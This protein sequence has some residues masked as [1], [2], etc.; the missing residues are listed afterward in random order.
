MNKKAT[1]LDI[2]M[3]L[4]RIANWAV[5]DY[6]RKKKRINFFLEETSQQIKSLESFNFDSLFK[7]TWRHFLKEYLRL[8]K[9]GEKEP[10]DKLYWA[11]MMMTWG[12]IL[13]HRAQLIK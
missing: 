9:E 6:G 11:E 3:N 8:E 5:D 4:N 13:T 7:K 12:N 10:K 2:A 1:V